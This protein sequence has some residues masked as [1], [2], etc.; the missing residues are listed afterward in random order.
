[1]K[2]KKNYK[3]QLLEK[4]VRRKYKFGFKECIRCGFFKYM[5]WKLGVG[6]M[7]VDE[8]DMSIGCV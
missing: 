2:M 4:F 7:N 8:E 5:E 3:L 1:M 6:G